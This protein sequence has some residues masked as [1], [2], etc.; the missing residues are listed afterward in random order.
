MMALILPLRPPGPRRQRLL[1]GFMKLFCRV[2][3]IRIRFEGAYTG[4]APKIVIA[5][6]ISYLDIFVVG[7]LFPLSFVAKHEL[8]S[9]P[10][11]RHL[12][13]LAQSIFVQRN[14]TLSRLRALLAV[15]RSIAEDENSY[16]IFP[17][18]TT[19]SHTAPSGHLWHRGHAWLH[20]HL[21]DGIYCMG[22]NYADQNAMAWVGDE[23][24]APHLLRLLARRTIDVHIAGEYLT[25]TVT[26]PKL[27]AAES[28]RTI[29]RLSR[30]AAGL[31]MQSVKEVECRQA[32]YPSHLTYAGCGLTPNDRS[33]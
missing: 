3:G 14:C 8:S 23:S 25:K 22:L 19:T 6:H 11:L 32:G 17:E 24:L 13:R 31:Q 2:L 16:C 27:L 12:A 20:R 30:E 15:K 7:S 21:E 28:L 10:V 26:A 1:Q 5:N 29:S 18:G 9:W 4:R 33:H